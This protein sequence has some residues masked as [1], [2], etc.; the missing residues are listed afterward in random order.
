MNGNAR[1]PLRALVCL[2][3]TALF[4]MPSSNI[5]IGSDGSASSRA[6]TVWFESPTVKVLKN[7]PAQTAT[8]VWSQATGK[9]HLSAARSESEGFQAVVTVGATVSGSVSMSALVGAKGTIQTTDIDT[10]EVRYPTDI[11]P[12]WPDPLVPLTL[13]PTFTTGQN[14]PYLIDIHVPE[15]AVPG[16]YFGN[17]TITAGADSSK[18]PVELT[19]WNITYP[20]TPSL[21][22]WFDDAASEWYTYYGYSEYSSQSVNLMKNVWKQYAKY[23][24]QPGNCNLGSLGRNNMTVNAGTVSV[25]FTGTD[26]Y[27]K[28]CLEDMGFRSFRFPL[29]GYSPRRVDMPF[30]SGHPDQNYYWGAPPYDMNQNYT[31]DIGQY[32]K[33]V[34]DHYKTKGWFNK[35]YVYATDEPIAFNN[36][37]ASYFYWG[38]PNFHVVQQYYNLS[39]QKAP[40][41]KFINTVQMVPD[42]WNYTSVWAVP[43]GSYHEL[44]AQGRRADNQSV[45]W[46]NTDAGITSPGYE[47]RAIYWDTYARGVDGAL[48][49][50]TNYWDY[51]SPGSDPWKGSSAN[52][53]GYLF[54]PGNKVGINDNV[55]PSQRLIL[56]R[57][58]IEDYELLTQYGQIYGVDAARAVAES[59]AKGSFFASSQR[60]QVIDDDL[61]YAVRE[62]LAQQ[63]MEARD[64]K[65]WNDTFVDASRISSTTDLTPDT[66]WEGNLGLS[67]A[68]APVM[69]DSLDVI[70]GWHPN[71]QPTMNSS[72]AIDTTQKTQG[73]G[74]LKIDWWRNNDPTVL[75]GYSY[76][77]NGRVVTSTISP[78]DWSQY[79]ILEMDVRSV[80]HVPGSLTMLIGDASG[81]VVVG[82]L[83]E[84][85]RYE[86]GPAPGWR[87]VVIDISRAPRSNVQYIE[88]IQYNYMM[89]VPFHHY[90]Y[91]LD[92]ITVRKSAYTASGSI[93][94]KTVD[95]GQ[96]VSQFYGLDYI[97]Q[98]SLPSGTSLSFETRTSSDNIGWSSWQTAVP[99]G[100]FKADIKSPPGRYIQYKATFTSTGAATPVLSEVRINF[101][102]VTNV[103][104]GLTALSVDPAVPNNNETFNL[105]AKV[106]DRSIAAV[107]GLKVDFYLG[108]PDLSG[109][110]LGNLT[111]DVP[112]LGTVNQTLKIKEP[113]GTYKFFAR[114]TIPA[115]LLDLTPKDNEMNASVFVNAYPVPI[116]DAPSWAYINESV[117]FNASRSTDD[118][119]VVDYQW[120][121]GSYNVTGKVVTYAYNSS[122]TRSYNLTVKDAHGAS[123]STLGTIKIVV[124]NPRPDFEIIPAKGTV[125]TNFSFNSL[126][127]DLDNLVTNYTWDFGDGTNAYGPKAIHRFADDKT[128]KVTMKI[129]FNNGTLNE[130]EVSKNVTLDNL[131]PVANITATKLVSDKNVL[132]GFDGGGSY[133]PDD[134]VTE[135]DF[136]WT[137]G[138]GAY[139]VG[140]TASHM[141]IKSGLFNVTLTVK[142]KKGAQSEAVVQVKILNKA[143]V[144]EFTMP[145]NASQFDIVTFNASKSRDPDGI[146]V[147]YS[148]DFGDG[149]QGWGL[150]V[151]HRYEK[152]G[153]FSVMLTVTDDTGA[154][155]SNKRTIEIKKV[156][157]KPSPLP[158]KKKG[159]DMMVVGLSLA[160]V[161]AVCAAI[162]GFLLFRKRKRQ[163]PQQVLAPATPP[164]TGPSGDAKP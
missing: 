140:E 57:D 79:Q 77:R 74:S 83:H 20:K 38:H 81:T 90:S 151:T 116:I 28:Y 101:K 136:G 158:H 73:T 99:S 62:W 157:F 159:L 12:T 1:Y 8:A 144:A 147:N 97:S 66:A 14:D 129:I 36:D 4:L 161:V 50:G 109:T 126:T 63:I 55:V 113:A 19:V 31:N 121:F 131:P 139:G 103:D 53:D 60:V 156:P 18:I 118:E 69:I 132:I 94:S 106:L 58:G 68:N 64:Y 93:A 39:E 44:D 43:G 45:W 134:P 6:L 104:L 120:D 85:I 124:R 42:L 145:A 75:G 23:K 163:E 9:V 70:G 86:A 11:D 102:G 37:M 71:D 78:K 123:T 25:D 17:L 26:P 52:G 96:T 46:Y 30:G 67:Y 122:G 80:E 15:T 2:F 89:A 91:W 95:L 142:D 154:N 138:D 141:Y 130:A 76:M 82:G 114:L 54:Y 150:D 35:T 5:V 22:T 10:F 98:W 125:L 41:I 146:I 27:L 47:G 107:N 24:I 21:F 153:N 164:D 143:P 49:W 133:D 115:G 108:D 100:Q 112:A 84:F 137:F 162:G 29:S 111:F 128:Y 16:L 135:L 72:V 40:G 119:G 34:A 148:W 3:V 51:A 88:P 7:D 117:H 105:T 65:S 155:N 127:E 33:L 152:Y 32:I 149:A 59:V 13:A 61:I 160:I 56:A 87:H 110:N 48:Y 92:N